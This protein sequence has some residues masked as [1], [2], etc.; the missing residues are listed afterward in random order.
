V[1]LTQ[2]FDNKQT[3]FK[4]KVL[5]ALTRKFTLGRN[6]S[7][8]AIAQKCPLNFTGAD[9]YALCSDAMVNAIKVSYQSLL[10]LHTDLFGNGAL[11]QD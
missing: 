10:Y 4:Q 7:L 9:F 5:E 11:G 1:I 2:R 6:V 8:E 3:N